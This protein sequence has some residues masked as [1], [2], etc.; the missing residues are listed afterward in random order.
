MGY[1]PYV[2]HIVPIFPIAKY[3][4]PGLSPWYSQQLAGICPA[5]GTIRRSPQSSANLARPN[6][7][8]MGL[9]AAPNIMEHMK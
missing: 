3:E 4:K 7:G 1:F 8:A 9:A 6:G 5:T 2:P